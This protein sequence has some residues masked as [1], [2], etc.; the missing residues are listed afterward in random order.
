MALG[1]LE[2]GVVGNT[3]FAIDLIKATIHKYFRDEPEIVIKEIKY[4]V[5][6]FSRG[7]AAARHFSN[8]V[9]KNDA[10]LIKAVDSGTDKVVYQGKS[11]SPVGKNRFIGL[12]DTVAA[13]GTL[14]DGFSPHDNNN[15]DVELNLPIGGAEKVFQITAQHECRYNFSL[16]SIK[17][18]RPEIALHGVHSDIGGGYNPQESDYLFLSKPAFHTVLIDVNDEDTEAYKNA[19]KEMIDLEKYPS[20]YPLT[21]NQKMSVQTGPMNLLPRTIVERKREWAQR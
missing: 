5:F 3:D 4:D 10:A 18:A 9:I 6:G 8:R 14:G 1:V 21:R 15:G 17:P 13:V 16:N 11:Q 2:E 7:A 20:I 19:V 12:F